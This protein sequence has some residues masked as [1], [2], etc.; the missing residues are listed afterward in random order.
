MKKIGLNPP[1][2]VVAILLVT[3]TLLAVNRHNTTQLTV[4]TVEGRTKQ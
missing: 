2:A 1:V 4:E 3:L